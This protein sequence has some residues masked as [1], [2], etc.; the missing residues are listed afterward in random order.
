M[1]GEKKKSPECGCQ[2]KWDYGFHYNH[3]YDCEYTRNCHN[4]KYRSEDGHEPNCNLIPNC[5]DCN[6]R[7]YWKWSRHLGSC[8]IDQDCKECKLRVNYPPWRL[9]CRK[10]TTCKQVHKQHLKERNNNRPHAFPKTTEEELERL[11]Q[12]DKF[13]KLLEKHCYDDDFKEKTHFWLRLKNED[14]LYRRNAYEKEYTNDCVCINCGVE[15]DCQSLQTPQHTHI[16]Q[17]AENYTYEC[18]ICKVKIGPF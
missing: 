9:A 15:E 18:F 4:C 14:W 11:Q 7:L 6:V 2:P 8:K 13:M 16:W 1:A 5:P 12:R 3:Y 10:C 17:E